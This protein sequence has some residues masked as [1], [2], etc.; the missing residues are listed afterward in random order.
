MRL[1]KVGKGNAWRIP[2][3]ESSVGEVAG[4]YK[5]VDMSTDRVRGDEPI[6]E[7]FG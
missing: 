3:S 1:T 5:V 7:H 2:L 6:G 4:G